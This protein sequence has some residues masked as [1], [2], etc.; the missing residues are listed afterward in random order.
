L[1]TFASPV[2]ITHDPSGPAAGFIG[3][4]IDVTAQLEATDAVARSLKEKET[5]LKE[6]HHRV[7]NNLQVIGSIIGL[8][9]NRLS[10]PAVKRVFDDLRSRIH[11]IALLHERLY[12]SPDLG[13]IDLRDYLDGLVADAAR[14][15]GAGA[16][17]ASVRGARAPLVVG[18]DEAVTVGMIATELVANAFKHG[19]HGAR[20]ARVEVEL[21]LEVESQSVRLAVTDDG[22]GFAAGFSPETGN[23]L[24]WFLLR[25]L[26]KQLGGE[27]S[28]SSAPSRVTL[29]FPSPKVH[30]P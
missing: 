22:P 11:A 10:D 14:A 8:Q 23:T 29:R 30:A 20:R 26:S 1:S 27:L 9:A 6:V 3:I 2:R 19:S 25:Q 17:R 4:T 16:E 24:G 5:L 21:E 15:A 7:K 28:V 12:R 18:M 13:A